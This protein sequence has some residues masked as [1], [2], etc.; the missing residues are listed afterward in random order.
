MRMERSR[1]L[2][3]MS[4]P[5]NRVKGSRYYNQTIKMRNVIEDF[6]NSEEG[7]VSWQ[8][9]NITRTSYDRE[10]KIN[11]HEFYLFQLLANSFLKH[12]EV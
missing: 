12:R 4:V 5:I 3:Q 2:N 9:E 11:E 8:E 1:R 7:S 10:D 6:I